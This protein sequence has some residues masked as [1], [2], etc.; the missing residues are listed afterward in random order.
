MINQEFSDEFDTLVNSSAI[1]S[2]D[3]P[4]QFDEY[5]KSVFLTEAQEVVVKS[6]Y[7]GNLV[8]KS[9]EE[10]EELRRYLSSLVKTDSPKVSEAKGITRYS[11]LFILPNDMWFITY[12]TVISSDDKLGCAKGTTFEVVPVTQDELHKTLENPFRGPNKRR[13]LRLD[14]EDNAVELISK[15]SID[16][17]EVRY[18][19]KPDP[20]ILTDLPDGLTINGLDKETECKLN[21]N[22][23]R[24]ILETAVTL[25]LKSRTS[26]DK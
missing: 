12:E 4:R 15:Y 9:F 26:A 20:I 3:S 8:G 21:S 1:L 24:P 11:T 19:A 25:A 17:Y 23:H 16:N 13:V 5:E 2:T 7:N 18:L 22:L 14:L 10:T 6:L